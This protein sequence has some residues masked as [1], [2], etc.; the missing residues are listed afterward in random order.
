VALAVLPTSASGNLT[1]IL[2]SPTGPGIHWVIT[3]DGYR[4]EELAAFR[5]GAIA[6]ANFVLDTPAIAPFKPAWNVHLL[7]A[8]SNESGMDVPAEN[9]VRDTVFNAA[10][11]CQGIDRL[12]CVD[13]MRVRNA[14]IAELPAYDFILVL[15]NSTRYGG[16]G[17][18]IAVATINSASTLITIHEFGHS[19]A[20]LADEY[21]DEA[22]APT[23]LL[24]YREDAFANVTQLS[25]PALV[26]WRHW[27]ADPLNVPRSLGQTGVGLFEGAYYQP[28]GFFRPKTDSFMRTLSREMG[29]VN[30]EAWALS[31]YA[32]AG[33]ITASEP[34]ASTVTATPGNA[35]TFSVRLLL[36]ACCADRWHR[37][38]I[39]VPA[40]QR[41]C[42]IRPST[43]CACRTRRTYAS[44]SFW[45]PPRPIQLREK[46]SRT[47]KRGRSSTSSRTSVSERAVVSC[48]QLA[49]S[50]GMS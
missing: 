37:Q 39:P 36:G 23:Y 2:G 48:W 10:A 16:S 35:V 50:S 25:T 11:G 47:K 40:T 18:A 46:K 43:S 44:S 1:T 19:F 29:E 4:G 26:K 30:T 9:I 15:V 5:S 24:F 49:A 6:A 32:N 21:V 28:T 45:P 27:F 34:L 41:S 22:A 3:G 17:G 33:A 8:A 38:G 31:V 13:T 7:D 12:V 42:S 14:V 20:R